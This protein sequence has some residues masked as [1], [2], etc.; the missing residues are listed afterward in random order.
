[1]VRVPIR[2]DG[3]AGAPEVVATLPDTDPDGIAMAADG[4]LWVTLYRPDGLIRV[5]PDGDVGVIVD[6]HLATTFDAPTNL[7]WVG[8][9]LDRV[10]IAN[11]GDTF[12]SIADVGV[13]GTPLHLPTLD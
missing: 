4:S 10:V 8:P 9:S 3:S 13:A 1:V 11:V 5:S 2:D 7:A 12:L 6:D